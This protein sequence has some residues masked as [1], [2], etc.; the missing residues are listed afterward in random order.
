VKSQTMKMEVEVNKVVHRNK[1]LNLLVILHQIVVVVIHKYL[2]LKM[3]EELT[4][5][6]MPLKSRKR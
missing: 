3:Q 1:V 6:R 5:S 4:L 2:L